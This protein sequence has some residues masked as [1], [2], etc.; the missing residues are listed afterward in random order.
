MQIKEKLHPNQTWLIC[1][2]RFFQFLYLE[3]GVYKIIAMNIR[4]FC[5]KCC[6]L[7][8]LRM[9]HGLMGEFSKPN[10]TVTKY[11]DTVKPAYIEVQWTWVNTSIYKK[12]DITEVCLWMFISWVSQMGDILG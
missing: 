2:V 7:Y 8:K 11:A 3:Y 1:D 4:F 10:E 6:I 5:L 12:F 9:I